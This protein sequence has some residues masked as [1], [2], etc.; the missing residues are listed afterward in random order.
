MTTPTSWRD[1]ETAAVFHLAAE[2]FEREVVA[3]NE[4]WDAQR[5]IDRSVWHTAGK[6]GLLLC[7]IPDS[8]GGGGGTF[9]HDLAV[10]EAQG[11]SGDLSMVTRCTAVSWRTTSSSTAQKSRRRRGCLRWPPVRCWAPSA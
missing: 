2:F 1:E 7:P 6:L 11:Y 5:R 4:Q 9:A 10:F 8:Y 3:R